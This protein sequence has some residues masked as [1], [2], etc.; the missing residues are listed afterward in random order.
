MRDKFGVKPLYWS[1]SGGRLTFASELKALL[2]DESLPRDLDLAAIDQ[3][4]TFR[5][6][7]APRTLFEHVRK[8][9]PAITLTSTAD[10]V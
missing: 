8:L 5:F 3:Y 7:P 4:L 2:V 1:D 10:G 9:P 6:V